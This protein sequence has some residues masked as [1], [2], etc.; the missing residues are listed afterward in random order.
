MGELLDSTHSEQE[1]AVQRTHGRTKS[2]MKYETKLIWVLTITFG[3]VF[4]DRNAASFLMPFI[5]DD[6]HF[7]NSQ[8]GLVASALSFTWAVGAFLG[9]AYSDRTGN[10]KILPADH[11]SCIFAVLVR[12]RTCGFI[13]VAV[14][15]PPAD[16][17]G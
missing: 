2:R 4:F 11:R 12:L 1:P 5:A 16:G 17:P 3:F 7:N 15:D 8:I 6:L 10:R 9:G 14:F 13:R